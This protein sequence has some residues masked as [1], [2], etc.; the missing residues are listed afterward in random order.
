MRH[1]TPF[2]LAAALLAM[3]ADGAA[4]DGFKFGADNLGA[5]MEPPGLGAAGQAAVRDRPELGAAGQGDY[6]R[7]L[8]RFSVVEPTEDVTGL[9]SVFRVTRIL[10]SALYQGDK[11]LVEVAPKGFVIARGDI[12]TLGF[13]GNHWDEDWYAV[14]AT[15]DS[16]M[17]AAAGHPAWQ[18]EYDDDGS[19][20]SCGVTIGPRISDEPGTPGDADRANV[21]RYMYIGVPQQ[22]SAIVT[23]PRFAGVYP[24]GPHEVITMVA[25]C[26]SEWCRVQTMYDFSPGKWYV[27][28]TIRFNLPVKGD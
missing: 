22:F 9:W 28:S 11:S 2:V 15:G 27:S 5:P 7:L 6:S 24:L 19:L 14:T 20:E 26:G 18:I 8:G 10:C 4:Q 13:G 12:H 17:D 3:P 16:E 25:P 23:E 1:A 21:I